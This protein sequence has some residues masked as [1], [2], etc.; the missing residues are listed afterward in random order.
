[1]RVKLLALWRW[2]GFE[3]LVNTFRA[4]GGSGALLVLRGPGKVIEWR[5]K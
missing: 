3:W 1:V 2:L 4:I 5:L